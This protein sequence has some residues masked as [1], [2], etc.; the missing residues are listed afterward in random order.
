[1]KHETFIVKVNYPKQKQD[2]YLAALMIH[3]AEDIIVLTTKVGK[4]AIGIVMIAGIQLEMMIKEILNE[5][6]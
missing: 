5:Y 4:K 1:M 2:I 6:D 3:T